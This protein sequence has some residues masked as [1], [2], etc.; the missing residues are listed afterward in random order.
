MSFHHYHI[1]LHVVIHSSSMVFKLSDAW[2]PYKIVGL[3]AI[4]N[5]HNSLPPSPSRRPLWLFYG[6]FAWNLMEIEICLIR[7]LQT[8]CNAAIFDDSLPLR[9]SQHFGRSIRSTMRIWCGL[10]FKGFFVL[11]NQSWLR[12]HKI[13]TC[14]WT[15]DKRW[16]WLIND[17]LIPTGCPAT[18]RTETQKTLAF[19]RTHITDPN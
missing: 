2:C 10:L 7:P 17:P 19:S 12:Q 14:C 11:Q 16:L 18:A 6:Y 3:D 8:R 15:L 13:R 5:F 4:Y 1:I 9:E